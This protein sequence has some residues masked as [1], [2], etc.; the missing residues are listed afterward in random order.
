ML[1]G[2][3]RPLAAPPLAVIVIAFLVTAL[4]ATPA[5]ADLE[6]TARVIDG[7]TLEVGGQR[8]RLYGIDAPDLDQTCTRRGKA[9]QCGVVAKSAL[10][11]LT[12]GSTVVCKPRG[13]SA[14]GDVLAVCFADRYDLS[15]GMVH[16]GWGVAL[17]D[18]SE[19]YTAVEARAWQGRRGLWHGEFDP[20]WEWRRRRDHD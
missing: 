17:Q 14:D 4:G 11:D 20:P 18:A 9:L 13:R 12:A 1:R 7:R 2:A 15:E 10:M 5:R 16:T 6:G 3:T 19:R 8:V